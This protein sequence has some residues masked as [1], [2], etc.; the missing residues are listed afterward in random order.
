MNVGVALIFG[1]LETDRRRIQV[2]GGD[3]VSADFRHEFP[4][5][6]LL[7]HVEIVEAGDMAPGSH[8]NMSGCSGL[9]SRDNDSVLAR[10]QSIVW[11]G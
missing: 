9:C 5:P 8:K 1:I 7:L 11:R 3:E 4:Q 10:G 2:Q 6:M